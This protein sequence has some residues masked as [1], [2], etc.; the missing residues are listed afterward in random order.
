MEATLR[1]DRHPS[2]ASTPSTPSTAAAPIPTA[3]DVRAAMSGVQSAVTACG[4]GE[5]GIATVQVSFAGAT[6]HVSNAVVNGQFAGTSVG[7]CIARAVRGA[8]IPPFRQST[9]SVSYPFRI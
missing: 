2:T 7:S 8:S 9:F 3:G 4:N 5:H 1:P 6:G